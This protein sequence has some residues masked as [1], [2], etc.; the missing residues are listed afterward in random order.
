MFGVFP[1]T[2][3]FVVLITN[4][5]N[6]LDGL[7]GLCIGCV[8]IMALHLFLAN[9]SQGGSF[10]TA[11]ISVSLMGAS[12]GFLKYNFYPAKIF[13]GDTGSLFLGFLLAALSIECTR[14]GFVRPIKFTV[15]FFIL[16][17]PVLDCFV[18][19]ARR[20]LKKIHPFNA[21]KRHLH[22]RFLRMGL[23]QRIA[24]LLMYTL[25]ALFS[26]IGLLIDK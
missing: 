6:L 17:L 12:I 20:L 24:C 5:I 25:T 22:H 4:A 14:R 21:D 19:V 7:D 16:L 26:G 23:S 8:G 10:L 15:P 18:V 13:M 2:I 9:V 3:F 1:V 11:L